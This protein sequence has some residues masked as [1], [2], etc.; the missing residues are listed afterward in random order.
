MSDLKL[1]GVSETLLI[2]L[3][4]RALE[5]KKADGILKDK[6]SVEVFE[7]LDYDFEKF[8]DPDS[9]RSMLRTTIRTTIIDRMV[10]DILEKNPSITV[11][12]LG[13]G[14]NS[15]F[16]RLDNS[17]V[18]WYDLDV[19]E[20]Y[21]VW[22][23][24]F[25]ETDRRTFLPFSAFDERWITKVKQESKG[26]WL[27]ISEASVI[28]FSDKK[29]QKLFQSLCDH[30]SGSYYLFDSAEPAFLESLEEDNDA[31]KYCDAKIKWSIEDIDHLKK[32]FPSIDVLKIID[33]E[34]ADHEYRSLYPADFRKT[35]DGYQ[36]NLI[37]L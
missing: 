23:N 19:P 14:L 10:E 4:G 36:L 12:E 7:S 27:F 32:K 9:K 8:L 6:K 26:P 15:R 3:M 21:E 37:S 25:E 2:P 24:F 31:L 34:S 30:F 16:E 1:S 5:T 33:L 11:V 35:V 18:R 28:Y 17:K 13:S 22:Q 29:V 20:V